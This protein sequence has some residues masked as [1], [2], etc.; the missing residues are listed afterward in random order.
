MKFVFLLSLVATIF[1]FSQEAFALNGTYKSFFSAID[2]PYSNSADGMVSNTFR[3]KFTLAPNK[4]FSLNVAYALSANMQNTPVASSAVAGT[5]QKR[6]YRA[7]DLKSSLYPSPISDTSHVTLTQNLDRLSLTSSSSSSK[8]NLN[9][10]RQP[11]AFGSAKVVNPTDVLTP[12][13]YQELDKEER[14][15]VDAARMNI[16]LGELSLF[17]AGY[18]FGDK[19]KKSKSS[20]FLRMK[21]N[22]LATDVSTMLLMFKRNLLLGLDISRSVGQAST[23]V[24]AAY[25]FPKYFDLNR[26]RSQDYFRGTIGLDYKLTSSIYSYCEY[27]YNGAGT[28]DPKKYFLL[29][30]QVPYT[31]GSVSLK[32]V[33][34]LIP[35]MS[36]EI[37]PIWKLTGQF[38][39]NANDLSILN[40]LL[41]EHSFAQDVFI[42]LGTYLPV[43]AKSAMVQK[44]EFG[45]YPKIY[46]TALRLYF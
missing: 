13:T 41:V 20:F 36:Y 33:H 16:S 10:G 27:H 44:S 14:V 40:N 45:I 23:W 38:L 7:L 43:G 31:E 5:Q 4:W 28:I 46:Y 17:D 21:S 34:Y 32:G 1:F 22:A 42:D 37:S 29:A 6:D 24:E 25:V 18:V 35:G 19:F 11:V 15:G 8:F 12:F 30:T 9:I 26:D 39:F 3:P 2:Y